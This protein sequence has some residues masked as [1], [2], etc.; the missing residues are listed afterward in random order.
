MESVG[1]LEAWQRWLAGEQIGELELWWWS[2]IWWGRF[3]QILGLA[4]VVALVLEIIGPMRLRRFGE[5]IRKAVRGWSDFWWD[6]TL[7]MLERL[8]LVVMGMA[9]TK[10][11]DPQVRHPL[12]E[13]I[14]LEPPSSLEDIPLGRPLLLVWRTQR[15]LASLGG[16][17]PRFVILLISS[18]KEYLLL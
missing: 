17:K 9:G 10:P 4:G 3:G 14:P 7:P 16:T 1:L 11:S 15:K 5:S 6:I 8:L 13:D 18:V 2:I 12:L